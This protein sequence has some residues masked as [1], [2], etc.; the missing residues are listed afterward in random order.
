MLEKGRY[1]LSTSLIRKT[2]VSRSSLKH[3]LSIDSLM[4]YS[5]AV[6]CTGGSFVKSKKNPTLSVHLNA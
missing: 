5:P 4:A 3:N 2:F 1:D 6:N